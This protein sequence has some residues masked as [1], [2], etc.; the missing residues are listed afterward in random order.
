M[1]VTRG[2]LKRLKEDFSLNKDYD[3]QYDIYVFGYLMM[4]KER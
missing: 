3:F 4:C 2:L 1:I